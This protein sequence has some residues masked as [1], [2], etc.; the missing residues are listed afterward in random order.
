M[1]LG[2][3]GKVEFTVLV[4]GQPASEA[5]LRL[6]PADDRANRAPCNTTG[7][8]KSWLEVAEGVG[9]EINRRSGVDRWIEGLE[10][11]GGETLE[12]EV[13]LADMGMIRIKVLVN[14]EPVSRP[15]LRLYRAGTTRDHF[16]PEYNNSSKAYEINITEGVWDLYILPNMNN[17]PEKWVRGLRCPEGAPQSRL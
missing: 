13:R 10:V 16:R 15:V 12:R 6:H 3:R 2:G 9:L 1:S 4:N 5:I 8:A 7:T 17:L 11:R 14:G